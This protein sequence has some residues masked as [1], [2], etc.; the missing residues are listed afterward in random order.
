MRTLPAVILLLGSVSALQ[1]QPGNEARLRVDFFLVGAIFI[2]G[3]YHFAIFLLRPGE[4]SPLWFSV[5]CMLIALRALLMGD[6]FEPAHPGGPLRVWV[7]RAE[8]LTYYISLPVFAFFLH[9]FFRQDGRF[10]FH[11]IIG[12]VSAAF[13]ILVC[14][15]PQ[16]IFVRSL[17]YY[18]IFTIPA[19]MWALAVLVRAGIEE[20]DFVPWISLGGFVFLAATAASDILLA[21]S[22]PSLGFA[23]VHYGVFAFIFSQSLIIAISNARARRQVELL[24]EN[25]MAAN[26]SFSRFVPVEFLNFLGRQSIAETRLGDQVQRE[27]TILFSDIRSFTA[28]SEKMT[29]RENFEFL[30]S[31]LRRMNPIIADNHGF[32][33][34]YIGDGIM[35]LF[36]RSPDDAVRAAVQMQ[37]EIRSY[38]QHRASQGYDPIRVGMGIHIGNL[39]LGTVGSPERMEST[40]IADAVNLASRMEGLTKEYGAS[41]LITE[42]TLRRLENPAAYRLRFVDRVNVKGKQQ[43]VGVV[44]IFPESSEPV[45]QILELRQVFEAG[46]TAYHE[47]RMQ[48]ALEHFRTV[49]EK[50][51]Q[52]HAAG[53]Y[54][55][56]CEAAVR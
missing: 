17:I 35:A 9:T 30:N 25:L 31:Y 13:A 15:A 47:G 40:V 23:S 34:K 44:E 54:V 6:Y 22:L 8:Y 37:L 39:I 26:Q 36:P 21:N 56:R 43:S 49:L 24:T 41:I 29:P 7:L 38:N 5:F 20:H 33:D 16:E 48:E 18:Q 53:H 28:M 12:A 19:A 46:V 51:P 32:V 2:I 42:V 4:R 45:Q 27:M 55:A 10:P 14:L 1:A 11:I 50:N 3:L 52:D